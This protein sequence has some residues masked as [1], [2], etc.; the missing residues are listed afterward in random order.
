MDPMAIRLHMFRSGSSGNCSLLVAGK[1][2]LLIDAGIGPRVLAKELAVLGLEARD[3]T[4]IVFTHCHSDHLRGN[5]VTM[6][7]REGVPAYL[8]FGTWA[9]A[10]RRDPALRHMPAMGVRIFDEAQPFEVD[11]LAVKAFSVSHG[12]PGEDNPAGAPVGFLMTDGTDTFGYCTDIGHVT[13]GVVARLKQADML[14]FESNHDV[15]MEKL[16]PRPYMTKQWIMGDSGHLSNKQAAHAIGEM[17]A[18]REGGGVILAH[19]SE[20][21]NTVGLARETAKDALV[22]KADITVGVANRLHASA[23][24]ELDRGVARPLA[25]THYHEWPS[26]FPVS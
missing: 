17:F 2:R 21:C 3:L 7:A 9:M 25:E 15:E 11:G 22:G 19:L 20:M 6:L 4:G 13:E 18:G 8:N 12:Q 24:W 26:L 23:P 14:V 1:T 5:T 16:S 10:C